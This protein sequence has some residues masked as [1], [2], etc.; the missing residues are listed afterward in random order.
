MSNFLI[1]DLVGMVL[2]MVIGLNV[3]FAVL[4]AALI[5]FLFHADTSPLVMMQQIQ[6]SLRSFP[7]LAIPFF[8]FAGTVMARGGIAERIISFAQ[9]MVGHWRGGLAQV[10]VLN[11]LIM[12]SM[13]GS[14]VADAAIDSR[15]LVPQMRANGYSLGF[16]SAIS[17]ASAVIAPVLPP[18]TSL[19]LFGL[20]GQVSVAQLFLGG[21]VPAFVIALAL[22]TAVAIIARRRNYGSVLL[23]RSS[24]FERLA[25]L[26]HCAWALLMP[27]LL[28]VGLRAGVFTIT[29]LSVMAALYTLA[30]SAFIYR[31]VGWKE[32]WLILK[33]TAETTATVLIIMGASAS[34]S[35]I[36]AIEQVPVHVVSALTR[37]SDNPL[38][39]LLLLN[40]ALLM[41]GMLVEGAAIMIL[42][43]PVLVGIARAFGIDEVH[44]GV[45][46]ALNLTI[47]TLTPPVGIVLFTI[48]SITGC[49]VGE[50][51]REMLPFYFTLACVLLL[52]SAVPAIV[53]TLPHWMTP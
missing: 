22:M 12:G 13:S 19:I 9:V 6:T 49:R 42:A 15:V 17:A 45:I 46:V 32:L 41:L 38:V 39:I 29:E 24:R 5:Y 52:L 47:G 20:L 33:E 51:L 28:I 25:A 43:A 14:A 35:Y 50:F 26:R 36:F 40:V 8:V 10:A 44:M 3:V 27:I 7:L 11:S 31:S 1:L 34:F 21:V 18:S 48:C 30:V 23:Q 37:I 2:A 53:L 16:S 4:G